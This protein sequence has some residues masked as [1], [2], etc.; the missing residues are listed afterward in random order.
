MKLNKV[1][2]AVAASLTLGSGAAMAGYTPF[3]VNVNAFAPTPAMFGTDGFTELIHQLGLNWEATSTFTD[4]DN[5]GTLNVGDAVVDSGH[6]MV[7]AYLGAG[8]QAYTGLENAEG[9]NAFHEISFSYS[10]LTGTVALTDGA[11][12]VFARYTSGTIKAVGKNLLTGDTTD[13]LTLDV[14][15]ST[16]A[17]GN[18]VIFAT[19]GYVNPNTFF[20]DPNGDWASLNTKINVRLDSNIDPL[21][22]TATPTGWTRTSTLDGSVQFDPTNEVPEPG[23][24]ALL[25]LGLLGLGAA[26]RARKS[27]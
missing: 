13:L 7:G 19:V 5:S 24:L 16:G 25:G 2:I 4:S 8:A 22:L 20:F 1:A 3:T 15:D 14:F 23:V 11:N 10:D 12:G 9:L 26:R 27:A 6:G 17:I 18:A 21:P